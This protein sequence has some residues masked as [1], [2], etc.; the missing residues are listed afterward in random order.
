[1]LGASL[2]DVVVLN[3]GV[4][5]DTSADALKRL[6]KDVLRQRPR[7]V[8][9]MFGTNDSFML[10]P[11]APR[12]GK[13]EFRKNMREMIERVKK[14]GSAPVLLTVVPLIEGGAQGYFHSLVPR[15][16]YPVKQ[17][18]REYLDS[19]NDVTRGLASESGAALVDLYEA[20]SKKAGGATDEALI[21]S[22]LMDYTGMHMAEKGSVLAALEIRKALRRGR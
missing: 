15:E 17:G 4:N 8:L 6:E 14:A 7:F 20:F 22:G 9:I 5:G 12:V 10:S 2:R 13:D 16:N 18:P 1:M 3:R 11:G 21:S 19:Y